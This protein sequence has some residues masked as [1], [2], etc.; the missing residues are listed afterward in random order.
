MAGDIILWSKTYGDYGNDA[1]HVGI[2]TGN[3]MMIDRSTSSAPVRERSIDTFGSFLGAVRPDQYASQNIAVNAATLKKGLENLGSKMGAIGTTLLQVEKKSVT[4]TLQ[5]AIDNL[6]KQ[7]ASVLSTAET[8][9]LQAKFAIETKDLEALKAK[10]LIAMTTLQKGQA[11]AIESAKLSLTNAKGAKGKASA[12]LRLDN[13]LE[14]QPL[15]IEKLKAS[16]AE[17]LRKAQESLDRVIASMKVKGQ[18]SAIETDI[19]KLAEL[20]KLKQDFY[21]NKLTELELSKKLAALGISVENLGDSVISTTGKTGALGKEVKILVPTMRSL[22]S[23]MSEGLKNAIVLAHEFRG[24]GNQISRQ[25]GRA[26]LSDSQRLNALPLA[27]K[28]LLLG[29]VPEL[30]RSTSVTP[31]GQA[32]GNATGVTIRFES[33]DIDGERFV[34]IK[35][36]D[37]I[38]L[39]VVVLLSKSLKLVK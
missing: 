36:A 25:L 38:G 15:A 14:S 33:R 22:F 16:Q 35:Q 24:E 9:R 21:D 4:G 27:Y 20:K 39:R 17:S 34:P 2:A 31:I 19:N 23:I 1:T 11:N 13:L 6:S 32:T 18:T 12:Q 30:N 5:A 10:N 8:D 7:K 37:P 3:G 29:R 28:Q 26:D